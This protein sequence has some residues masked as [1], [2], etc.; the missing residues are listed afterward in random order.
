MIICRLIRLVGEVAEGMPIVKAIEE[1][2]SAS[3]KPK[4]IIKI[5]R[6]GTV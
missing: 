2:G 5:A 6:S 3:G 1:L 4:A